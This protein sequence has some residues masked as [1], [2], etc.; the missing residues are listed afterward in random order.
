M[1]IKPAMTNNKVKEQLIRSAPMCL[2]C[3]SLFAYIDLGKTKD[4]IIDQCAVCG[5]TNYVSSE[6]WP[7]TIGSLSNENTTINKLA[8][9]PTR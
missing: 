5:N 1:E 8:T 2:A 3:A 6:W 7:I 4:I 9:Y